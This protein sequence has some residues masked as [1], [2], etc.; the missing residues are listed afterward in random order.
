MRDHDQDCPVVR[1]NYGLRRCECDG[2]VVWV[3]AYCVTRHYG[4]P[5]EGGWWYDW[6]ESL[7]A[8]PVAVSDI[9]ATITMLRDKYLNIE[10]GDRFSMLGGAA[11][12]VLVDDEPCSFETTERPRYE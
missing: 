1:L 6:Y 11:V 9:D 3:T 8:V 7:Q 2:R 12:S 10:H 5:E 4:G